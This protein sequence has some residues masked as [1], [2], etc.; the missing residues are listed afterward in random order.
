MKWHVLFGKCYTANLRITVANMNSENYQESPKY[1]QEQEWLAFLES[2]ELERLSN[3]S[4]MGQPTPVKS[5]S[6]E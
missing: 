1:Q 5:E 3:E 6:K 2:L 4:I